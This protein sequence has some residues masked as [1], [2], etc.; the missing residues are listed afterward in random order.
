MTSKPEDICIKFPFKKIKKLEGVINYNIIHKI[1]RDIQYN[2]STKQLE[3][4]GGKN[5][6]LGP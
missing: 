5:G 4:G 3:L 2:G 6:I 1:H